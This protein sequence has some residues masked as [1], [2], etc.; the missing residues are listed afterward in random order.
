[1]PFA[2]IHTMP[3]KYTVMKAPIP[4][5]IVI[6]SRISQFIYPWVNYSI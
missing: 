1:M 5:N 4:N 2:V 6:P 3:A